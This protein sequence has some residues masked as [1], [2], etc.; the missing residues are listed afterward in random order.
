MSKIGKVCSVYV[1]NVMAS[2]V[3]RHKTIHENQLS[4]AVLRIMK[5]LYQP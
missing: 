1:D 3:L 4:Q 5:Q 2:D